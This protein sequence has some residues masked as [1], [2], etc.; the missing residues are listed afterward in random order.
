MCSDGKNY[1]C[2]CDSKLSATG[3]ILFLIFSF[4]GR[5]LGIIFFGSGKEEFTIDNFS[6]IVVTGFLGIAGLILILLCIRFLCKKK[7]EI[8]EELDI[9]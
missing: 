9:V 4:M 6:A 2:Q 7:K 8:D 3:W 5:V 1:S